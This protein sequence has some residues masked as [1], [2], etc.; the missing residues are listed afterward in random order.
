ML[1]G[2]CSRRLYPHLPAP[3]T[4]QSLAL[5]LSGAP[6]LLLC[7]CS[8]SLCESGPGCALGKVILLAGRVGCSQSPWLRWGAQ[9]WPPPSQNLEQLSQL[10]PSATL[11]L[12]QLS[13]CLLL[14]AD[15]A[16]PS[17]PSMSLL[18][19]PGL[20]LSGALSLSDTPQNLCYGCLEAWMHV[21][22][23]QCTEGTSQL[24]SWVPPPF[25]LDVP[26]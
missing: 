10:L 23:A 12:V 17:I 11:Q 4:K 15:E 18:L 5:P 26:P 6:L 25:I 14:S 21:R 13:C 1:L 8:F 24:C 7:F 20:R 22:Q 19:V 3:L 16:A 2:T 9:G